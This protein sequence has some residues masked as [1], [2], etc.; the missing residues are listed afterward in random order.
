M[1]KL[2]AFCTCADHEC[3]LN[4]VNHD[5]GCA[6]CI[7]KNLKEDEVPSCIWNKIS[8]REERQAAD[9]DYKMAS[10]AEWM[11]KSKAGE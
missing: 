11:L 3:P 5:Q 9:C 10:F 8:T 2:A 6:P 4:P 7:A 1:G